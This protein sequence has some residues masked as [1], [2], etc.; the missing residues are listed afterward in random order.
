MCSMAKN[1][2][3]APK[4]GEHPSEGRRCDPVAIGMTAA[5]GF[6][7]F[8]TVRGRHELFRRTS[9]WVGDERDLSDPRLCHGFWYKPIT[10]GDQMNGE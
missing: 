8:C 10:A 2:E 4:Y 5:S 7:T 3:K 1:P 6:V 9:S